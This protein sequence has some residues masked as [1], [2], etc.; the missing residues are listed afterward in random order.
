MT[1][2]IFLARDLE[3]A[4]QS[5][6]AASGGKGRNFTGDPRGAGRIASGQPPRPPLLDWY[7]KGKISRDRIT[8]PPAAAT[9]D[10]TTRPPR[11][12]SYHG[13]RQPVASCA[14][15]T[16]ASETAGGNDLGAGGRPMEP[17]RSE[18]AVRPATA[19]TERRLYLLTYQDD[20]ARLTV[21]QDYCTPLT[22][23]HV[24]SGQAALLPAGP[25]VMVSISYEQVRRVHHSE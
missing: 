7:I 15:G 19:R 17:Q 3:G 14:R 1:D 22:A 6:L 25:V 24:T 18:G 11:R 16:A 13:G 12:G 20:Q 21:N 9:S 5:A 10:R 4:L 23:L 8:S 2:A